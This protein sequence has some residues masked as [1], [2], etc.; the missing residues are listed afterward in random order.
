MQFER[1][2]AREG[3]AQ[4]IESLRAAPTCLWDSCRF[5]IKPT[6]ILWLIFTVGI[7][8]IILANF[9]Y[10]DDMARV[11]LGF[12]KWDH[13]SRYTTTFLSSFMHVGNYLTDISPLTQM[14][15]TFELAIAGVIA[16]YVISGRRQ[17]NIWLVVAI[18]PL[19]LCPYF[20]ECLSYKYDSPY[21]AL[22]VL[23]SIAPLL[24]MR[25]NRIV[26]ALAVIAGELIVCTT[27]Q[28]ASGILPLLVMVIALRRWC[29]DEDTKEILRF[30]LL[31]ACAY[32]AALLIFKLFLMQPAE[33][34]VSTEIPS[35]EELPG[36]FIGHLDMYMKYMMSDFKKIW[37]ILIALVVIA[38]I[39]VTIRDTERNR[40]LTFILTIVCLALMSCLTFGIYPALEQPLFQPRA[41]YGVG[42]FIAF[43]AIVVASSPRIL[44]GKLVIL[45]LSW[46][47]LVFSFTYGNA[48]Y[49]QIQWTNFRT[50]SAIQDLNDTPEF[51]TETPKIVQ[52]KGGIGLSPILRNQPQNYKMLKR[53]IPIAFQGG[54]QW[55][56]VGF[57]YYYGLPNVKVESATTFDESLPL[58]KDTA[59][60]AIYGDGEN[61]LVVLK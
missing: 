47:F 23:A 29:A 24:L 26:F 11:A 39:W 21:M 49:A 61:F 17:L 2:N 43:L 55:G 37:L 36:I 13:F 10:S 25:R 45:A 59:Y 46:C 44:C 34:Y 53:L 38:F 60:Q 20:L 28:A 48:L 52:V 31:S 9:N 1:H 42:A 27:Y 16:L 18:L 57:T 50:T 22:S 5:A 41:M 51:A 12:K 40:M 15:A 30:L 6:L 56:L 7:S 35:I 3:L 58:L 54:E 14:V 8:A 19:G 33:N 4:A 32:L